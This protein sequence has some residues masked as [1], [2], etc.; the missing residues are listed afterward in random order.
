MISLLTQEALVCDL[1]HS[2]TNLCEPRNFG[3]F[4]LI[5]DRTL[6]VLRFNVKSCGFPIPSL[7][8]QSS[9]TPTLPVLPSLEILFQ[10]NPN[11]QGSGAQ[12]FLRTA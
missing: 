2:E 8:P 12:C 7:N 10:L 9:A 5:S 11:E 4:M 3:V 1:R 6:L